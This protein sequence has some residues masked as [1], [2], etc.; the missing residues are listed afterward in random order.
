MGSRRSWPDLSLARDLWDR[1]RSTSF[2]SSSDSRLPESAP[3]PRAAFQPTARRNCVIARDLESSFL[4]ASRSPP[5]GAAIVQLKTMAPRLLGPPTDQVCAS[6]AYVA[7]QF[8]RG[9]D[10]AV[11][12]S[13]QQMKTSPHSKRFAAGH[14]STA[15]AR[16]R[17]PLDLAASPFQSIHLKLYDELP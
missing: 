9:A 1:R 14:F 5:D 12:P 17:N 4:R 13:Q 11:T 2:Y 16:G 6:I 15:S 7:W 3:R 10:Q 8:G